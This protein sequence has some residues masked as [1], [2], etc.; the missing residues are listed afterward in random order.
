MTG[1]GLPPEMLDMIELLGL[2]NIPN[3][4]INR[5][6]PFGS[7]LKNHG[8]TT[9]AYGLL[10]Y[11]SPDQRLGAEL[12]LRVDHMYLFGKN[13]SAY[14]KPAFNPRL[15]VDYNI[16]K[17]RGFVDSL[18]FTAGAGLFSSINDLVSFVD[19]EEVAIVDELRFNQSFTS[20]LGF[21]IDFL[22]SYSF[23]IEGYYKYIFNRGYITADTL[24]ASGIQAKLHS[25]GAGNVGGFDFQLQKLESRYWDGWVSYSFNWAKYKN[26]DGGGQGL[27]MGSIESGGAEWFFPDFHRFHNCNIVLNYKP[28][29]WFNITTRFGFASGQLR[30]RTVYK[31]DKPIPYPV[32]YF[33]EAGNIMEIHQKYK[34]DD[35]DENRTVIQ[36]RM[37]WSL[38]LD[39]KFSFFVFDK[40]G[41]TSM[42]IYLAGE[43]LLWFYRPDVGGNT[44]YNEYTGMEDPTGS[45]GTGMFDVPIPLVSFGFKW[46]Y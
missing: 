18:D 33:D 27:D 10:E 22:Q 24:A 45:S 39:M 30:E 21:K 1:V 41:R 8:F 28:L 7:E 26:P 35:S 15:N 4:A 19:M 12:G 13:F 29:R 2:D 34:R 23:N 16:L 3:L 46:R 44:R 14:T 32:I 36:E 17:N 38:S 31:N 25:D 5:P 37:P 9:S 6:T 20:I 11:T 40:K 43:N 42:E